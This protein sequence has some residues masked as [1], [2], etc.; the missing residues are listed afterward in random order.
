MFYLSVYLHENLLFVCLTSSYSVYPSHPRKG[1]NYTQFTQIV[2]YSIVLQILCIMRITHYTVLTG[3][4]LDAKPELRVT[5][6]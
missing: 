4:K 6:T 5:S 3:S 2:R 1:L